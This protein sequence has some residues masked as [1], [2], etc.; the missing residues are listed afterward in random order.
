MKTFTRPL[1][2]AIAATLA[3]PAAALAASATASADAFTLLRLD[4]APAA[5][6]LPALADQLQSLQP[7]AVAI[8]DVGALEGAALR[9]WARGH[10]YAYRL[11]SAAGN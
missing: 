11:V 4:R 2:L 9:D 1:V 5:A 7:D 3:L 6:Q 10:G 8:A